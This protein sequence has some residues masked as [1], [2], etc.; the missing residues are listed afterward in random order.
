[1][2]SKLRTIVINEIEYKYL[3]SEQYVTEENPFWK[4]ALRVF[5]SGLKNTGLEIQF[6]GQDNYHL[7]N[8]LTCSSPSTI[9]LNEPYVV[10]QLILIGLDEG[11][12]YN[13]KTTLEN[14]NEYLPKLKTKK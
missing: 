9:N 8:V 4:T 2:K 12:D 10:R 13:T 7:G 14:G 11:W 3:I 5:K 6:K 1:M